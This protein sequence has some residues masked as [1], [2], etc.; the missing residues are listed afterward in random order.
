MSSGPHVFS[1]VPQRPAAF[2]RLLRE[3]LIT[4]EPPTQ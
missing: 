3:R 4:N 2:I 1:G